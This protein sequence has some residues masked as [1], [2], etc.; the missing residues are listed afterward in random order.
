MI[1]RLTWDKL[2]TSEKISLSHIGDEF[3]YF[4]INIS[5]NIKIFFLSI[6]AHA[7]ENV[8]Y[9][10]CVPAISVVFFFLCGLRGILFIHLTLPS[11]TI[12]QTSEIDTGQTKEGGQ[13]RRGEPH[14]HFLC[15][16]ILRGGARPYVPS[17]TSRLELTIRQLE[18][19]IFCMMDILAASVSVMSRTFCTF[20][21]ATIAHPLA[22]SPS[23]MLLMA[24]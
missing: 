9:S 7:R 17:Y 15:S 8:L 6:A 20:S 19:F 4:P 2:S 5:I 16:I 23:E 10:T 21:L 11:P 22:T 13:K 24:D 1:L 14:H 18:M 3:A 12:V